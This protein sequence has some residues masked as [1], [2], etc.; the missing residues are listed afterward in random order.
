MTQSLLKFESR[1]LWKMT[2]ILWL[3]SKI[4]RTWNLR[5]E[6]CCMWERHVSCEC[7]VS[8]SNE[9]RCIWK[10]TRRSKLFSY[11]PKI[12]RSRRDLRIESCCMRGRRVSFEFE[13]CLVCISAGRRLSFSF[14]SGSLYTY[15]YL[16][17]YSF[18]CAQKSSSWC[19]VMLPLMRVIMKHIP[20]CISAY[21]IYIPL[22][23]C[24]LWHIHI[25]LLIPM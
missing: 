5:I 25:Y 16:Y 2:R 10:T 9:S 23:I 3:C 15:I 14:L 6:S 1:R 7:V 4:C 19:T 11:A 17:I 20:E 21:I 22:H 13:T 18:L 12:F 8:D 24:I